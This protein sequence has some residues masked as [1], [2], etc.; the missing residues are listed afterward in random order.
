M[1]RVRQGDEL[2]L[3]DGA[4]ERR[5]ARERDYAIVL[6]P[7]QQCW[8]IDA[9]QPIGQLRI[10]HA[11]VPGQPRKRGAVLQHDVDIEL[12]LR[13]LPVARQLGIVELSVRELFHRPREDVVE[14]GF[15]AFN[16]GRRQQRQR[17][18]PRAAADRYLGRD[19]AA[20][21]VPDEVDVAQLERLEQVE[22]AEGYVP[23]A[24]HPVRNLSAPEAGMLRGQHAVSDAERIEQRVPRRARRVMQE[25]N[26]R[27][28]AGLAAGEPRSRDLD[29]G[30]S[31]RSPQAAHL[32]ALCSLAPT[33]RRSLSGAATLDTPVPA[34]S[35]YQKLLRVAGS[36]WQA[37]W[38]PA[39]EQNRR[40]RM[41]AERARVTSEPKGG[42]CCG[43]RVEPP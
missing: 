11:R 41:A 29:C 8:N 36:G 24:Q 34:K 28:R 33:I 17:G 10:V 31:H 32:S 12:G 22:I 14:W 39:Q 30:L 27:A 6:A 5:V 18:K 3:R 7:D 15:R 9:V 40:R 37:V 20:Q 25:E 26:G 21:P 13:V 43:L 38:S 2:G 23:H 4:L 1:S 16:A 42:E 35:A 19:P